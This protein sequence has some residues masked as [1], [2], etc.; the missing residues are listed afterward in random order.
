ML[1]NK[2]AYRYETPFNGPFVIKQFCTNDTITSQ[3][4]AIKIRHNIR[5][6]KPYTYDTNVED[7]I[8]E[9]NY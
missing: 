7:I 4:G 3:C 9:T 5:R 2:D 6:I 1:T 8:P